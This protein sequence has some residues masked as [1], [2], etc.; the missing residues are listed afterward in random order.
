[1]LRLLVPLIGGGLVGNYSYDAG[2]YYSAGAALVHGRLPYADFTLLHPPGVVLAV[3]PAAWVGR[4]TSDHVGF[5]LAVL[6][7]IAL[8]AASAALVVVVAR[9]LGAGWRAAAAGGLFYA[10]WFLSVRAEYLTRLEPLGNFLVLCGLVAYTRIDGP[11]ARRSALLCGAAFGA[12]CSVKIWYA[13][14]L[15]VVLCFMVAGRRPRDMGWTALGAVAAVVLICGPLF[16]LAPSS[17]WRMVVAE[18]LGRSQSNVFRALV[19]LQRV[20]AGMSW[21]T[22]YLIDAAVVVAAGVLLV[23]AWRAP[24]VRLPTTLLLAGVGVLIAAPS[25]FLFYTDYL[26]PAA[27]LC[28]ATAAT[29]LGARRE[30]GLVARP[31]AIAGVLVVVLALVGSAK[32]LWY[33]RPKNRSLQVSGQLASA[34]TQVPCVMSDSPMV[35]VGLNALDRDLANGCPNWVDVTGRTYAPDMSVGGPDGRLLTRPANPRWQG[36]LRDYLLSGDAVI[37]TRANE[38]GLSPTTWDAIRA[39]GILAR[40]G[41]HII[42][43]VPR[44]RPASGSQAVAGFGA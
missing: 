41:T 25:W 38:E 37:V 14:P 12:A 13:V 26:T 32:S 40:D 28:V 8:G 27:A 11:H 31:F 16:A 19:L 44:R 36:A 3:A 18:Q 10:M 5:A 43:A 30:T 1:V 29:A 6:E 7:F 42:Y 15:A 33:K 34:V 23:A 24:A 22:A 17:M 39:G 20:P 35:L 21:P 2:V 9:G 4:L